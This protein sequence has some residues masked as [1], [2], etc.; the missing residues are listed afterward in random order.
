MQLSQ[1]LRKYR[2]CYLWIAPFYILF[3]TFSLYPA[4]YGLWIS[5]TNYDG[6][7]TMRF[8]GAKNYATLLSDKI[9]WKSLGNTLVLWAYIVPL[10]TI[11][12]LV[13][14]SILNSLKLMGKRAYMVVVL[15]PYVT[16]IMMVANVFRM[17]MATEGGIINVIL[18]RFN[19]G[20]IGWL[21]TIYLS[22]VSIAIMNLWRM[23]GYF[24]IVMLA[25]LQ[26]I[27]ASVNEAAELDG[28]GPFR[29]F[30]FITIPQ[31]TS[32]IFFVLLI[33][34]IWVFQNM[35]DVMVL[36]RGGP[37][38][39]SLN[40]VYYIYRNAFEF[41]KMG[42]ASAMSYILFFIL[43]ALSVFSLRGQYGN[44]GKKS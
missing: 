32:E 8:I 14:A 30:L 40:L 31:M 42:Y 10:R 17:L 15:L 25:G 19:I 20:P 27:S 11:L 21:D 37:I 5:L 38:N 24:S 18:A 26:K 4:V 7:G 44:I 36:T 3:S 29:K 33:S 13:F 34:T 2:H 1:E 39:S 22:K 6:F 43:M 41:S 28:S 16:A 12:A 23:T 35:G 9:F